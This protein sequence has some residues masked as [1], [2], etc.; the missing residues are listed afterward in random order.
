LAAFLAYSFL[1]ALLGLDLT[2]SLW[3][4]IERQDGLVLL[5]HFFA[6]ATVAAWVFSRNSGDAGKIAGLRG[7]FSAKAGFRSYLFFSFW[8][9][10]IV[11]LMALLESGVRFDGILHPLFEVLSSPVRLSGAF[12]LPTTLGPYLLFHFFCGIYFLTTWTGTVAESQGGESRPNP[13]WRAVRSATM[14]V[15]V[16]AEILIVIVVVAGQTRGVIFAL[17]CG[18]ISMG[19]LLV[20]VLQPRCLVKAAGITLILCLALA[21]ALI[22]RYRDSSFISRIPVLQRLTHITPSED[23]NAYVRL[24]A[25]QSAYRGFWD[26]P[27]FGWGHNNVY[28]ALNKH[29]DPRQIPANA[30][31]QLVGATWWDKSHNF[32]IDLAVERGIVGLLS[33]LF[34]LAIIARSL[35]RMP[36]RWLAI[37]LGGGLVGYIVSNAVAFDNFGSLFGFFLMLAGIGSLGNPETVARIQALLERKG[38]TVKSEKKQMVQDRRPPR[39]RVAL[40]MV[41]AIIGIYTNLEMAIADHKF[42]QAH[43]AFA[44]DPATGV[45]LFEQA[46]SHYSPYAAK[47]KIA[48]AYLLVNSVIN[49]VQVSQSFEAGPLILRLTREALAAH[50]QDAVIY[51]KLNDLYNGLALHM[52]PD[53]AKNAE[54]FGRTALELSPNRQEAMI[55][56]GRTYIIRN[57]AGLTVDLNRRMLQSHDFPL[58]HWLL[59]LSLLQNN[60]RE[61]ARM[62]IRQA[63]SRGYQLSVADISTLKGLLG[64]KEFSELSAG[65]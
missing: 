55:L 42:L 5:L 8:I 60:Q 64:E 61:E 16:A 28:Y 56:L 65:K 3:G 22:W 12:G 33:Y 7:L 59:G 1:S 10:T 58:G 50:P 53:F 25:W 40:L 52:N 29:Y 4:F 38:K 21:S 36:D 27:V 19:V 14:A 13:I 6:W 37:C 9:S 57:E 26:R 62:E 43:S 63:I 11:A 41:L 34:L 47:E 24:L 17:I 48:C 45:S 39:L 44:A 23:V 32:V 31:T 20:S 2:R 51:M 15:I 46:F 18:L 30:T 35:W 54:V 49:K